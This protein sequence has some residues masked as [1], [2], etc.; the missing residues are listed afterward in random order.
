M[1]TTTAAPHSMLRAA[2]AFAAMHHPVRASMMRRSCL[3]GRAGPSR[4]GSG[5]SAHRAAAGFTLIELMI[6]V[7]VVGVL[8][9]VALPSFFDQ[10]LKVRRSDALVAVMQ[11]QWAQERW[12]ANNPAYGN[13][14]QIGMRDLSQAGHYTL[15]LTASSENGYELVASAS[16]AQARDAQCRHMKLTLSGAQLAHASG[17]DIALGNTATANRQC[18]ML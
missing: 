2:H 3:P 5:A 16:G 12:R 10:L 7:T 18:W 8:S 15:T 14:A 13:L 4:R 1:H 11:V 6:A 17:P 9:T